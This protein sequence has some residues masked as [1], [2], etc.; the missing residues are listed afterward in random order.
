MVTRVQNTQQPVQGVSDYVTQVTTSVVAALPNIIAAVIILLIGWI[1][2][3]IIGSIVS[4][5]ANRMEL[6]R[7]VLS[8]PIGKILGGTERAVSKAF[9][10]L[11]K[12]FIYALTILAAAD[13]LS[14]NLLSE[15]ISQAVT[16]LPSFIGGILVIVLG[17]I[18]ADFIA[19]AVKRTESVTNTTYT[20]IIASFIR[21]FLYFIVTVIGLETIGVDVGILKTFATALAWGLAA[22]IGL[23][24]A[25]AFG[26]GGKDYVKN[27][28]QD[29]VHKTKKEN[30]NS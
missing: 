22:G 12:W 21:L 29:W 20:E 8:T 2:G 18:L 11:A 24:I 19:D 4:R 27:N 15:W 3:R 1:A 26:W 14:I 10:K 7:M 16:Y 6:D 30:T 17:F 23:A 13:V 9:G 28:I 5:L 25:I